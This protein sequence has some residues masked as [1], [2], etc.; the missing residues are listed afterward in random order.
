MTGIQTKE[1]DSRLIDSIEHA[2]QVS[3]KAV[4]SFV[5]SVDDAFPH[6]GGDD[7][8]RRR[9]IGSAFK[10]TEELVGAAN[11]LA[12]E[13]LDVTETTVRDSEKKSTTAGN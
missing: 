3:L 2:E 5:E 13:V 1:K 12:Q 11:R 4:R 7:S 10:M 6:L 8:P 9:I